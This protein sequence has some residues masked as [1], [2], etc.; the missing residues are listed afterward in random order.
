MKL[1]NEYIDNGKDIDDFFMEYSF[2][3]ANFL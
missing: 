1:K 2:H 3:T